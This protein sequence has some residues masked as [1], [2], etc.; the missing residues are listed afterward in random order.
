MLSHKAK[1]IIAQGGGIQCL[2]CEKKFADQER[3]DQHVARVHNSNHG[4][5]IC[6]ICSRELKSLSSLRSHKKTFHSDQP[7]QRL[8]CHI[9]GN[10]L[11]SKLGMRK[12]MREHRE[13]DQ[14]HTCKECG[15]ISKSKGA[16]WGH[17]RFKHKLK[18][19]LPCQYCPKMFKQPLDVKEHESTHTDTFLYKCEFCTKMFKFG[20]SYRGHRKREHPEEYELVKPKWMAPKTEESFPI[21]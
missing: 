10:L 11:K 20:A 21:C 2:Q 14:G 8:P 5:V 18:R 3:V 6:E 15:Q 7:V 19:N 16:L 13:K 9:C 4:S 1:E 12:H 17:M